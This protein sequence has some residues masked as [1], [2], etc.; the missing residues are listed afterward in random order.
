[1]EAALREVV[2]LALLLES[3]N[4]DSI[5]Y[6]M[7]WGSGDRD[8]LTK[9]IEQAD[10]LQMLGYSFRTLFDFINLDGIQYEDEMDRIREQTAEGVVPYGINTRVDPTLA[11]LM[12][13]NFTPP[14]NG[15]GGAD[16]G[17][18]D[19]EM[20]ELQRMASY[21]LQGVHRQGNGN[22]SHTLP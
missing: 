19:D 18:E 22:G 6:T 13:G 10:K 7:K 17:E 9:K 16:D 14:E 20:E 12:T 8:D 21:I 5:V 1:M 2:D 11:A 3:I 15:S 4:P